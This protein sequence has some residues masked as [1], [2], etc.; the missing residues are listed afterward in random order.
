MSNPKSFGSHLSW[1]S[2]VGFSAPT[3]FDSQIPATK[4]YFLLLALVFAKL[5]SLWKRVCPTASPASS[6]SQKFSLSKLFCS[7]LFYYWQVVMSIF[8]NVPLKEIQSNHQLH[9]A[10]GKQTRHFNPSLQPSYVFF[11][12]VQKS[13]NFI[14]TI[15]ISDNDFELK[16]VLQVIGETFLML[17]M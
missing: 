10:T 2:N 16:F 11:L 12:F 3:A 14:F 6:C 7:S 1:T 5:L 17:R 4:L 9:S 15:S 8:F 13:P